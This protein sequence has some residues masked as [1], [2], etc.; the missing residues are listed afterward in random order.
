MKISNDL[1]MTFGWPS[2]GRLFVNKREN[3]NDELWMWDGTVWSLSGQTGCFFR[4]SQMNAM[5]RLT[6][7]EKNKTGEVILERGDNVR[8]GISIAVTLLQ[9]RVRINARVWDLGVDRTLELC[10]SNT[11]QS[12]FY[13]DKSDS[14]ADNMAMTSNGSTTWL[15]P[16]SLP[17]LHCDL[18]NVWSCHLLTNFSFQL[19]YKLSSLHIF[20]WIKFEK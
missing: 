12:A 14:V 10:E 19:I 20:T 5:K 7:G 18:P 11:R 2:R 17:A 8:S 4:G 15:C 1:C 6:V 9:R 16:G 3:C 13:A